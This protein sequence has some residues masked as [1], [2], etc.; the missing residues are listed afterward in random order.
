MTVNAHAAAVRDILESYFDVYPSA[1]RDAGRRDHDARFPEIFRPSPATVRRLRDRLI[2]VGSDIGSEL[3]ADARTLVAWLD[4]EAFRVEVLGRRHRGPLECLSEV[5]VWAY[6]KQPYPTVEDKLAALEAHLRGVPGFLD[7]AGRLLDAS[8]PAGE[9]MRGIEFA[10]ALATDI[11]DIGG[12]LATCHPGTRSDRLEPFA[13]VAAAACE[14]FA[15]RVE[16]TTATPAVLGPERLGEWVRVAEAVDS[17]AAELVDEAQAE[18]DAIITALDEYAA[19]LGVGHRRELYRLMEQLAPTASVRDA[20][21]QAVTQLRMF[22]RDRD[23]VDTAAAN[24]LVLLS[25][26]RM[27]AAAQFG[28]SGPF[29]QIGHPHYLYLPQRADVPQADPLGSRRPLYLPVLEMLA[30]HET[31]PGHYLHT[32]V[33]FRATHGPRTQL[34]LWAGFVEGWAHYAEELA[35]EQG[36]AEDRPLLHVAQL[37]AALEAAARFLVHVAVHAGRW[38]FSEA[39][40]HVATACDWPAHQAAR[41]VLTATWDWRSSLYTFGKLRIRQW[42]RNALA[43][44]SGGLRAFHDQLLRCGFAPLGVVWQYYRDT[45][46]EVAHNHV[47]DDAAHPVTVDQPGQ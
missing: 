19:R 31:Y 18:L 34:R 43:G 44:E 13:E 33:A 37:F 16:R 24:P 6:V 4:R 38:T 15:Q 23:V 7:E 2:A 36:L 30:V 45:Q 40:Q 39:V 32:E 28:V 3:R 5:D 27:F 29:E 14:Q 22:W 35:I 46:E 1:A 26:P 9:R 10:H 42:R 8:L 12:L 21:E 11:R 25:R 20:V 41:E 47:R 17:T